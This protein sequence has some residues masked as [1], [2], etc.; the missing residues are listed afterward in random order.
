M[1]KTSVTHSSCFTIHAD[2]ITKSY[3]FDI[4]EKGRLFKSKCTFVLEESIFYQRCGDRDDYIH[5]PNMHKSNIMQN[6]YGNG[7]DTGNF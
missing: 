5:Y 7:M 4:E 1:I 2:C 6:R 3:V